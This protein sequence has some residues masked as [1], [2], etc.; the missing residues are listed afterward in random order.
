MSTGPDLRILES[1]EEDAAVLRVHEAV[2]DWGVL[3]AA[4]RGPFDADGNVLVHIIRPC[5][6]KGRG[7]HIYEADM[8]RRE[9]PKFAGWPMYIDH[10]SPEAVRAS[11]GLPPSIFK[12]GGEVLESWW[13]DS[14][15]P[16]GRFEKGAVVGR[17]KPSPWMKPVIEAHPRLVQTSLNTFARDVKPRRTQEGVRNVVE[18]FVDEGSVDWVTKAGAGGK[19]VQVMEAYVEDR[20]ATDNRELADWLA[21]HRPAVVE[22]LANPERTARTGGEEDENVDPKQLLEAFN[23]LDDDGRAKVAEAVLQSEKG[24]EVVQEA[25]NEALRD[26]MPAAMEAAGD[27]IEK[28]AMEAVDA[29]LGQGDLRS[30][31]QARL[32]EAGLAQAFEEDAWEAIREARFEAVAPD[33]KGEGG[34]S[35]RE[36]MEAV[37]DAQIAR[38]KRLQEAAGVKVEPGRRTSVT[39]NG[40]GEPSEREVRES[41]DE[42]PGAWTRVLEAQMPGFKADEAYHLVTPDGGD[43]DKGKDKGKGE[44]GE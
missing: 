1:A 14:V 4:G 5:A 40:G 11:G 36:V 30:A 31:A 22:A 23:G 42:Q 7:R 44:G 26:V 8:L 32:Q 39:G 24:A 12:L 43:A 25:V 33:D 21:E 6:G 15:P 17:V 10:E 13:D 9:A 16:E 20:D 35:A 18:G 27:A 3:E 29:K 41:D 37:V 34:K 38:T 19:I 2:S 28:R